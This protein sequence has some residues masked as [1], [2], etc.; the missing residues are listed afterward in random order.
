MLAAMRIHMSFLVSLC[1]AVPGWH[2]AAA[3]PSLQGGGAR[4]VEPQPQQKGG[5]TTAPA[6]RPAASR[7][8]EKGEKVTSGPIELRLTLPE[9]GG[10]K[11]AL[12]E[13]KVA[14]GYHVYAPGTEEGLPVT[15][16]L[17]PGG[18][19]EAAGKPKFPAAKGGH[20]SGTFQVEIPFKGSAQQVEVVF[21]FQACDEQVCYP[22][23]KGVKVRAR[24]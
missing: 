3:M 13:V 21:G 14:P 7:P 9:S 15:V 24:P 11:V 23:V 4:P 19:I 18:G 5:A 16:E 20:L 1:V 22:P 2:T 10:K 12:L 17:V 8:A 6:S